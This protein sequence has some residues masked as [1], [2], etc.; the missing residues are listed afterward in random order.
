MTP[1]TNTTDRKPLIIIVVLVIIAAVV[2]LPRL[3]N[4]NAATTPQTIPA[5]QNPQTDNNI[6]LGAPIS[7]S[8]LD[9]SGCAIESQSTFSPNNSIYVVAPES[10]IPQGTTLFVRLYRDGAAIEDAPQI[11]ANQDYF[12]NC[13]NFVFQPTGQ[14]FDA[15]SYEAQFF[16][17][18]NA[19]PSVVFNVQ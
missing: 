13:I 14:A 9:S 5:Q 4:N 19:G 11:T 15:G 12:N 2:L 18:G 3:F 6:Q 16:V 8:S 7:T 1:T 17:N 10:N